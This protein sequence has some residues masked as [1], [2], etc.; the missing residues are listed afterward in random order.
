[1]RKKRQLATREHIGQT[2]RDPVAGRIGI[3]DELRFDRGF[4][5]LR[6]AERADR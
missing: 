1:M 4:E 3:G 6:V 2:A 5:T